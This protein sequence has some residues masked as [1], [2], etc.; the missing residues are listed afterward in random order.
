MAQMTS[1]VPRPREKRAYIDAEAYSTTLGR[2]SFMEG[3]EGEC[4]NRGLFKMRVAK[5]QSNKK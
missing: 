3:S 2:C 1:G 4:Q 5:V